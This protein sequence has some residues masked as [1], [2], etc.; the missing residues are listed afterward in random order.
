MYRYLKPMSQTS[1]GFSP[2]QIKQ[3]FPIN[4]GPKVNRLRDIHLRSCEGII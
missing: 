3:I 2:D 4:M 1:P